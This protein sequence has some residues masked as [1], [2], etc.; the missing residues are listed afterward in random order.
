MNTKF[1]SSLLS[2][3]FI[4]LINTSLWA[5][6]PEENKLKAILVVGPVEDSTPDFIES[7]EKINDFLKSQG[8]ITYT[9][10]DTNTQWDKITAAS[11]G[12]NIFIYSGHGNGSNNLCLTNHQFISRA[13]I[14]TDLKLSKNAVVI[15]KSVCYG[16]GSSAGDTEDIGVQEAEKRVGN[17]AELFLSQGAACYYA[18]NEVSGALNF[19]TDIFSGKTAKESYK[20]YN[21][22]LEKLEFMKT[23]ERDKDYE[24]IL[25]SADVSGPITHT[26]YFNGQKTVELVEGFKQYDKAMIAKHHFNISMVKEYAGTQASVSNNYSHTSRIISNTSGYTKT[27]TYKEKKFHIVVGSFSNMELASKM[28]KNIT[29]RGYSESKIIKSGSKYRVSAK[30]YNTK[31]LA[32]AELNRMK[33]KF[34][35]A[36]IHFQ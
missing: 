4:S 14:I 13:Q 31:T 33:N 27:E 26:S 21:R 7:M 9:F 3:L 2:L 12:A 32:S 34:P 1:I 23:W 35:N 29:A 8:V 24:I 10:Y 11:K 15:F 25:S 6:K 16:A 5:E 19:L 18:N 28:L 22:F 30:A 17:Y 36:W 20:P